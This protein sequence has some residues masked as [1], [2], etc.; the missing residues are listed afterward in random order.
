MRLLALD[1]GTKRTGIAFVDTANNVPLPL[2]TIISD[3]PEQM[4]EAVSSIVEVRK[5]DHI[6]IGLPLLP[7]GAEGSQVSYVRLCGDLL[8]K[9]GF[10]IQYVDERYTTP[11]HTAFDGDARAACQ[12]LLT[13]LHL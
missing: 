8:Q 4:V 6:I 11:S 10:S 1:I 7:S 9:K 13:H 3:T 2:D 5:V 12:L